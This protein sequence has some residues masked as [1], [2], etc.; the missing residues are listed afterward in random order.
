[1]VWKSLQRVERVCPYLHQSSSYP[2][3]GNPGPGVKKR[4]IQGM[5]PWT[6][7]W[8]AKRRV[9]HPRKLPVQIEFRNRMAEFAEKHESGILSMR[10]KHCHPSR[11]PTQCPPLS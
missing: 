7:E 4:S 5:N 2:K 11:L 1:M 10:T 9:T 3:V 6:L 8:T